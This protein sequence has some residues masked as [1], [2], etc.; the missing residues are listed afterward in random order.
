MASVFLS[1]GTGYLGRHLIPVL[2]SRGHSVASLARPGAEARLPAGCHV[3]TGYALRASSFGGVLR[4]YDTF[5]H[6]TGTPKP[7]PWKE[8]EFRA[9]DLPSLMASADAAAAPDSGVRHFIYVSVAQTAPI[10]RAYVAVRQEAEAYLERAGILRRTILRPWYVLGP[11]HWWP[12]ALRPLYALAA[13]S[14]RYRQDAERLGLVTI[15]EMT[16][17]LVRAVEQ[18][19]SEQAARILGTAEI[20]AA[21]V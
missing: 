3:V 8:R 7:A 16:S 18:P 2:L 12:Y 5:I 1:G 21:R 15:G 9:V 10:M 6:L 4:G 17:A 20:R 11:G 13:R 19:P 14:A